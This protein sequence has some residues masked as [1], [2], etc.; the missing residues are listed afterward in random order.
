MNPQDRII[1]EAS[2]WVIRVDAGLGAAGQDAFLDWLTADPRHAAEYE[3]QRARWARLDILADWRPEHAA[4]PNRDLLAPRREPVFAWLGRRRRAFAGAAS[5][6]LAAAACAAAA[7]AACAAALFVFA[8][9]GIPGVARS[10]G[11]AAAAAVARAGGGDMISSI[12]QSK[13][14]DGTIVELNRGAA[15][16]VW[17]SD[18]ERY[19]RLERGEA[20]FHVAK[21]PLRPFI[22]NIDGVNLRALGTR[23]NV[24]RESSAVEV[25]VTAGV[26]QVH[27]RGGECESAPGSKTQRGDALVK[28]GQMAVVS[29]ESSL[30]VQ[31][32]TTEKIEN[33]IAWHPRLLDITEQPLSNVV[34]EFNRRNAPIRLVIADPELAET[35][36]SATL[37]SD[38]VENLVRM[39]EGGFRVKAVRQGDTVTLRR[40]LGAG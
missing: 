18:T 22:L 10:R 39:L 7:V 9:D 31:T 12:E 38:Q 29:R 5:G 32:V 15:I 4:R 16:T 3:R 34:A 24:R 13:L 8:P 40:R 30:T 14:D 6:A 28:A 27:T 23:F 20:N 21:D 36:V 33:L 2:A 26:V 17:Y 11:P 19:V 1:S 37:R 25:L 35:A